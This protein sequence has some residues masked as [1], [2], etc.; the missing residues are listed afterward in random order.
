MFKKMCQ[1]I[2]TLSVPCGKVRDSWI[3]EA[4]EAIIITVKVSRGKHHRG[5]GKYTLLLNLY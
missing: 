1:F 2:F 5:E 4:I 3:T